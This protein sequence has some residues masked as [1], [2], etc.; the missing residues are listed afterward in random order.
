[1]RIGSRTTGDEI[2]SEIGIAFRYLLENDLNGKDPRIVIWAL[3][4]VIGA[5]RELYDLLGDEVK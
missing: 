1:M 5:V 3:G 4:G 2:G